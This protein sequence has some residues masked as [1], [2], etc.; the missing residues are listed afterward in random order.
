M[1]HAHRVAAPEQV[2]HCRVFE[3][4]DVDIEV[5]V[6]RG[7]HHGNR[8][9]DHV[10]VA[11]PEEVHLQQ[12]ELFD[13]VH[14]ELGDDRCVFGQ[15][16]CFRLALHG[17]IAGHRVF[18]DYHGRGMNAIAALQALEA[19]GDVDDSFDFGVEVDH[20]AQL[21]RRLVPVAVARVIFEAVTQWRVAPHYERGHRLRDLVAHAVRVA[22]NTRRVAYRV[23][24][25]D[26]GERD[27]LRD[28]VAPVAL[29]C[30]LD[31]LVAVTRVEVHVDVGH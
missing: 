14:F 13:V 26:G 22:E 7:A 18:G 12:A 17:Q 31:H 5:G 8:V 24:R 3:R 19:L 15:A 27:D 25:L 4:H 2:E 21:G 29:R 10:E 28:V 9:G 20:R 23:A 6:F 11:Q 30:V 1:E 16:A